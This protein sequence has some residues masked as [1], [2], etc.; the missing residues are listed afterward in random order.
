MNFRT[1]ETDDE[2]PISN[3]D[4]TL[5]PR[6]CDEVF[7]ALSDRMLKIPAEQLMPN[8]ISHF[9]YSPHDEKTCNNSIFLERYFVG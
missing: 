4:V 2:V 5:D 6:A 7:I 8:L 1:H 3:F 9:W